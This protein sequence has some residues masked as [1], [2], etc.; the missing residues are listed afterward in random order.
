MARR[1]VFK[2]INRRTG[3]V[4]VGS[5]NTNLDKLIYS[6]WQRLYSGDHHNH[7]LQ[8]DFNYYGRSNFTAVIV[9]GSCRSEDEVRS[10]R[11]SEIYLNRHNT[12]NEDVPVHYG[13]GNPHGSFGGYHT[14]RHNIIDDL[15]GIIDKSNLNFSYK[16]TLKSEVRNGNI[17]NKPDLDNKIKYYQELPTLLDILN[18]SDLNQSDKEE[19]KSNI[20][21]GSIT[22]KNQLD[23][24]ITHYRRVRR[25]LVIL[26]KSN[27]KQSYKDEI[28]PHIK[29]GDIK[30]EIQLNNKINFYMQLPELLSILEKSNIKSQYKNLIR[31]NIR[32]GEITSKSQLN[33]EIKVYEIMSMYNYDTLRKLCDQYCAY[34]TYSTWTQKRDKIIFKNRTNK[35]KK[36]IRINLLKKE[37]DMLKQSI[38]HSQPPNSKSKLKVYELSKIICDCLNFNSYDLYKRNKI[39]FDNN[40]KLTIDKLENL[41]YELDLTKDNKFKTSESTINNHL[42]KTINTD[43]FTKTMENT[44]IEYCETKRIPQW[45]LI[46][47]NGAILLFNDYLDRILIDDII[48][49]LNELYKEF[50]LKLRPLNLKNIYHVFK[51]FRNKPNDEETDSVNN[52]LSILRESNL[53]ITKK[54][55][56]KND[57][58]KGNIYSE[59]VLN[60]KIKSLMKVKFKTSRRKII[61][62]SANTDSKEYYEHDKTE[63]ENN[64]DNGK[65]NETE[66][67]LEKLYEIYGYYFCPT[68]GKKIPNIIKTC[69]ECSKKQN[70]EDAKTN[71]QKTPENPEDTLEK[72]NEIFGYHFCPTCGKK[73]PNI[74]ETCD[75]CSKSNK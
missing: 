41:Y 59:D 4:Y 20:K 34:T 58:N 55:E 21:N 74:M 24:V 23:D 69:D 53:T 17:T 8:S 70:H 52:L 61:R 35:E 25:L 30:N 29:N 37:I 65:T 62:T 49:S 38:L 48:E 26:N 67:S 9:N 54:I 39:I 60:E 14:P 75:E 27:L 16:S 71:S 10:L 68:C 3:K 5:S 6:Y 36:V 46:N 15:I 19:I 7:E 47:R 22:N 13:G 44:I 56:L 64:G 45:D 1:G 11:D 31:T 66:D 32:K 42:N 51:R 43:N 12:Y 40:Y 18:K 72:L 50:D 63:P 73:I 57:I 33:D 2:I 28:T